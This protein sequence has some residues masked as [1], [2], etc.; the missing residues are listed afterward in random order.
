MGLTEGR[1]HRETTVQGKLPARGDPQC[2]TEWWAVQGSCCSTEEQGLG[3]GS[4]PV[5][6]TAPGGH[7]AG[8]GDTGGHDGGSP[9]VCDGS[10]DVGGFQAG[11]APIPRKLHSITFQLREEA[12]GRALPFPN[13]LEISPLISKRSLTQGTRQLCCQDEEMQKGKHRSH[14]S[15][16]QPL[17]VT[18]APVSSQ[19]ALECP[20]GNS[21]A[22]HFPAGLGFKQISQRCL[23]APQGATM[24]LPSGTE[25]KVSCFN[26]QR[27]LC[28]LSQGTNESHPVP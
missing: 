27:V 10:K 3:S 26:Y 19:G 17:A 14:F 25:H 16:V 20:G 12:S 24:H 6:H 9:K 4:V 11:R 22:A 28:P 13:P 15:L 1:G 7:W 2:P 23:L 18:H 5:A 8:L 21:S